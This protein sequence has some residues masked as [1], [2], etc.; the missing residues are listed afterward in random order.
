ML[1]MRRK[2][3]S[4]AAGLG[5]AMVA[6]DGRVKLLVVFVSG[7]LPSCSPAVDIRGGY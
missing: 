3:G 6:I 4:S 2:R 7:C 1:E 5:V